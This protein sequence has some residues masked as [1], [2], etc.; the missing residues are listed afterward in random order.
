MPFRDALT[1]LSQQFLHLMPGQG[2]ERAKGLVHQEHL[3]AIGKRTRNGD[4]LFHAARQFGR[5]AVRT[6]RQL[7]EVEMLERDLAA[8]R[9]VIARGLEGKLDVLPRRQPGK[10]RVGLED[11]ATVETRLQDRGTVDAEFAGVEVLQSGHDRQ[12]RALAATRYAD[13]RDELVVG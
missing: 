7:D 4:A 11:D 6:L 2:I 13:K 9:P 8:G 5:I 10:Q 12:Q 3:G 1:P